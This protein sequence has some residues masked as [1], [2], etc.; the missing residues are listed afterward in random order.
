M[1]LN[2]GHW[3][4]SGKKE[5]RHLDDLFFSPQLFLILTAILQWRFV[6]DGFNEI[7]A[8]PRHLLFCYTIFV[9]SGNL[10]VVRGRSQFTT[11]VQNVLGGVSP[12]R[13]IDPR[14]RTRRHL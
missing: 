7:V 2:Y 11:A 8:H 4:K 14:T 1:L 9:A 3:Q 10:P 13:H 6:A 5:R 12:R